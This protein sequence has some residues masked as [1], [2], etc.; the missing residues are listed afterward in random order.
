MMAGAVVQIDGAS[1]RALDGFRGILEAR[2]TYLGET[3]E[4]SVRAMMVDALK[5]LR[6]TTKVAKVSSIKVELK[7]RGDL[8]FSYYATG[9]IS[10]FRDRKN[11]GE[12][13]LK[14]PVKMCVRNAGG[15]R[16]KDNSCGKIRFADCRGHKSRDI[17]CYEFADQYDIGRQHF[18]DLY[19]IAAPSKGTAA[20]SARKIVATRL[21]RYRGLARRAVSALMIKTHSRAPSDT[22]GRRVAAKAY[23][24][25]RTRESWQDLPSGGGIFS[26]RATDNLR[27]AK[28]ALK[29]GASDIDRAL[30]ASANKA[31]G[32]IQ[33]CCKDLLRKGALK[34]PFP[35]IQ[36]AKKR[37]AS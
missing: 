36:T 21:L 8:H 23:E 30:M 25:T 2:Q 18:N 20:K 3:A 31:A 28:S 10:E 16:I 19:L 26:I 9:K 22:F 4:A 6:S 17:K 32:R 12:T 27:Y 24:V 13:A 35:E 29:G 5:S 7:E 11:I 1:L 37:R 14:V 33:H 34:T 15:I